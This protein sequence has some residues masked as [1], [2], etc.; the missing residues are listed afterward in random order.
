MKKILYLC[1]IPTTARGQHMK[2]KSKRKVITIRTSER[3]IRAAYDMEA[4]AS[5]LQHEGYGNIANGVAAAAQQLGACGRLL[6]E[7]LPSKGARP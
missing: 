3:L 6:E 4:L 1:S 7:T 2:T 5:A